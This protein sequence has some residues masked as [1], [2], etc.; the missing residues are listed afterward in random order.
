MKQHVLNKPLVG[1][2]KVRRAFTLIELLVVIAVI[3]LLAG[4]FL[5]VLG[6]AKESARSV[7]CANNLHQIA[8][9]SFI[10]SMDYKGHIPAFWEW[11][12]GL[13]KPTDLTTGRLY[14]Y[15]K[16]KPVYL[17]PT[18]K[19]ELTLK[20]R[21]RQAA[22]Q[23]SYAMNCHICHTTDLAA[24]V[25]PPTTLLYIEAVLQPNDFSGMAGGSAIPM[26]GNA[27]GVPQASRLLAF[28][29]HNRGHL[30]M[31]DLHVETMDQ[32]TFTAADKTKHFWLPTD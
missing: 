15:L 32:K 13:D 18:D 10:Y 6:K 24:F 12:H 20:P 22:R 16:A 8:V 3:A 17:C 9:A 2:P 29:H 26:A 7:S 28:R 11:L 4:L 1:A 14:P 5:P 31:A 30:V 21:P 19:L 23:Y 27:P 25:E